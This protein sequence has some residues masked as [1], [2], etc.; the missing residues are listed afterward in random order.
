VRSRSLLLAALA[1][2]LAHAP[3]AGAADL[4]DLLRPA[5]RPAPGIATDPFRTMFDPDPDRWAD[6]ALETRAGAAIEAE[7]ARPLDGEHVPVELR[8]SRVSWVAAS[9]LALG[10]ARWGLAGRLTRPSWSAGWAG[11]D[12]GVTFDGGAAGMDI[13]IRPPLPLAG[14]DVRASF[15]VWSAP[16]E[17]RRAPADV[18]VRWMRSERFALA[19]RITWDRLTDPI[20]STLGG[21]AVSA[22]LN[23]SSQRYEGEGRLLVMRGVVAEA[24]ISDAALSPLEARSAAP[25]YHLDPQGDVRVTR[26]GATLGAAGGPRL[27][28]RRTRFETS[29]NANLSWGGERFGHLNY[30][31]LEGNSWMVGAEWPGRDRRGRWIADFESARAQ[32]SGR[33]EI[34]SWPFTSALVD[35]LG[36]RRILRGRGE[37]GWEAWHIATERAAGR[38]LRLR[39]GAGWY[40]LRP[41]AGLDSWRPAF[42]VF[43]QEDLD[44]MALDVER[45]QVAEV[46]LGGNLNAAGFELGVDVRQLVFG[47]SFQ[48]ARVP[49]IPESGGSVLP[50]PPP[51][52]TPLPSGSH[53]RISCGR[54]F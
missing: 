47:K 4:L 14:V 26:A 33:A 3:P 15:P 13:A 28:A 49:G 30:A 36:A 25:I 2:V 38:S 32:L 9:P 46:A 37:V 23:L 43:G 17:E 52:R 54:R 44:R 27:V 5:A 24:S 34:E 18:L 12:R 10:G 8:G 29:A 53:V 48:R 39:A 16:G 50:S 20:R 40:D 19:G 21:E 42:L 45:L 1:L 31:R 7:S 11:S 41:Q 35:L 22:G 51:D 6:R